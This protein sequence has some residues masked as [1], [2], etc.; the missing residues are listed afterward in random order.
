MT[1]RKTINNDVQWIALPGVKRMASVVAGYTLEFEL[2]SSRSVTVEVAADQQYE[3]SLDGTVIARGGESGVPALW[4]SDTH[5]LSLAKGSHLLAAMVWSWGGCRSAMAQMEVFHGFYL[6][7]PHNATRGM[8]GTGC[9]PW[10]VKRLSGITFTEHDNLPNGWTG[11]PPS[12]T[13]D[14]HSFPWHWARGAGGKGKVPAWIPNED[15]GHTKKRRGRHCLTPAKLPLPFSAPVSLGSVVFVSSKA[16]ETGPLRVTDDLKHEHEHFEGLIA[17]REIVLPAGTERK[18]VFDLKEY[19]CV[20]PS[21]TTSGGKSGLIRLTWAESLFEGARSME[22]GNRDAVFDKYL[23]GIWDEFHLDGGAERNFRTLTWRAGRYLELMVKSG[24]EPVKLDL[25]LQETRFDLP[26]NGAFSCDSSRIEEILPIS[27]RSLQMSSHDNFVDCPFYER[28]LYSGDGRLEA[29]ATYVISGDD[30]LARKA[31]QLFASSTEANGLCMARWPSREVQYIPTFA[32]WWIGMVYDF[33]MWRDDRPFVRSVLP[34]VRSSLDY[35]LTRLDNRGIYSDTES[36]WNFVDWVEDWKEHPN[37]GVPPSKDGVNMLV[38]CILLYSLS[39][40]SQL[41]RYAGEPGQAKRYDSIAT[42]MKTTLHQMFWDGRKKLF[43]DDGSGKWF[44]EQTQIMAILCGLVRPEDGS[45]LLD[46]MIKRKGMVRSS[47]FFT[48]YLFEACFLA[49]REDIFF[50]RLSP[51]NGFLASGFT[52]VPENFANTRSDCHGWGAHPLYHLTANV[53]GIQSASSGFRS[54]RIAPHI[55][56][57]Q[58]VTAS[59]PHPRG[60]IRIRYR[61]KAEK[62]IA[63]I[64]LPR[65]LAGEFVYG[66]QRVKLQAGLQTVRLKRVET[67]KVSARV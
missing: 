9:A 44:S 21:L 13:L 22:K 37:G 20:Y 31:I 6:S 65:G 17:G 5:Q 11:V 4:F 48:H 23:R 28:L 52:T 66:Q 2:L 36:V 3:L 63:E 14:A 38:N 50:K 60:M 49:G 25:K 18:I 34:A 8:L 45:P 42:A 10:K 59:C 67:R 12:Q 64:E 41:E 58:D 46:R 32:L 27:L 40:A 29:L 57:L 43:Q 1:P 39:L 30:S 19:Y 15:A 26:V 33:S 54:V 47:L 7:S 55:G 62:I 24:S 51:W 53:A 56:E 61:V 35:F 16:G